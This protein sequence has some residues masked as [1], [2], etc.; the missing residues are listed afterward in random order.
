MTGENWNTVMY[1]GIIAFDGPR[2]IKGML[3]SLYF[4]ALVIIGNC[5]LFI[6]GNSYFDF[7][8]I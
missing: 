6:V 5:I 7:I 2:S 1:Q 8:L 4:V 3:V